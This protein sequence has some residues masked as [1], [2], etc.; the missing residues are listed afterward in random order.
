LNTTTP[1]L[2]S[3]KC[4]K[5]GSPLLLV[6]QR[7]ETV[8]GQYSPVT[9]STYNCSNEDCQKST[10]KELAQMA[11]KKEEKE[12]A[13]QMRVERIAQSRKIAKEKKAQAKDIKI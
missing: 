13:N 10:D 12:V 1:Q 2:T 5:C 7:T 6:D 8:P 9:T 4:H 3:R 11:K